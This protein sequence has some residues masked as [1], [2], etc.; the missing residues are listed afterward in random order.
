[1]R[2]RFICADRTYQVTT[3]FRFPAGLPARILTLSEGEEVEPLLEVRYVPQAEIWRINHGWRRSG[4]HSGFVIDTN[5]GAW[6]RQSQSDDDDEPNR[7]TPRA[8]RGQIRPYVSDTRNL[9]LLRAAAEEPDE[10]FLR[11]LAYS[12]R[13]AIQSDYQIEEQEIQVELIGREQ[14]RRIILWEAAEGGIGVWERLIEGSDALPKLARTALSLLHFDGATG[15]EVP[16]WAERC[17]AACY[18]CLLSYANQ[19]D[20]RY[21]D[22]HHVRDFLVRLARSEPVKKGGRTYVEQYAWLRERTDPASS[23]ERSFLDRLFERKLRLPD[24]AQH[25]PADDVFLQPDFYYRRGAIPGICVFIDGPNHTGH[26]AQDRRAREALED[27]G[28]RVVAIMADRPIAEQI[29]AHPDVFSPIA[30]G[31]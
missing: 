15:D 30:N 27:C 24:F 1:V 18:D 14:Q 22:R 12:L 16:G 2:S 3:H 10:D 23:F 20:H 13:R 26:E 6:Q 31:Q 29:A 5:T 11:S 4:D 25:T 28:Y 17:P 21:L 9:L 8:V 19:L 7:T